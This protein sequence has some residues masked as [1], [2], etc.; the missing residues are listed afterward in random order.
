MAVIGSAVM[1]GV[2][3]AREGAANRRAM[4]AQML[5]QARRDKIN[6]LA[7]AYGINSKMSPAPFIQP[8]GA[9]MM[10][11]ALAG[12]QFGLLNKSLWDNMG[13]NPTPNPNANLTAYNQSPGG[14]FYEIDGQIYDINRA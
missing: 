3:G 4:K 10:Q 5:E 14:N 12:A 7:A 13:N 9:Q 2:L 1:G 6:M 11:G 8:A